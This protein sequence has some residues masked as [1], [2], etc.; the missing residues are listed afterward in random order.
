MDFA[1]L[2]NARGFKDAVEIGTDLGR[3]AKDFLDRFKGNWLF[4]V[5]PYEPHP[6]FSYDRSGDLIVA[7]QALAP[8]HGRFRFVRARSTDAVAWVAR[9]IS[10]EFIYIDGSHEEPDVTADL[11]AWWDILPTRGMLAGHDFDDDHP[12]VIEAVTAFAG[13]RNLTV[14]LTHEKD[15]P[16]SWYI[17]KKE[18]EILF[19]RF[20]RFDESANA[21]Y[22]RAT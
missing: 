8:H 5:D 2:C 14:R 3:F 9:V 16:P 7:A 18:P 1:L 19:H 13:A 20:F 6:D 4:C 17:Y 12:G 10:P 21:A 15:A 11:L 22:T